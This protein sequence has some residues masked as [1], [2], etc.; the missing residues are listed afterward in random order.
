MSYTVTNLENN[1]PR[2]IVWF[3]ET[4]VDISEHGGGP[5]W[6]LYFYPLP[7]AVFF[8][9]LFVRSRASASRN[10]RHAHFKNLFYITIQPQLMINHCFINLSNTVQE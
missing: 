2:L 9:C 3:S 6:T 1:H 8:F 10:A 4:A 7:H 5:K